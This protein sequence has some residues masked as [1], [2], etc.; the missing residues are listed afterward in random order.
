MKKTT[1]SCLSLIIALSM[2]STFG[3]ANNENGNANGEG[4]AVVKVAN[5]SDKI[6]Q[7]YMEESRIQE[8]FMGNLTDSFSFSAYQNEYESKQLIITALEDVEIFDVEIKDFKNGEN[9]LDASSFEIYQEF[10]HEVNYMTSAETSMEIGYYPDALIPFETAKAYGI[11]KIEKGNNQGI[12][13]TLFV[14]KGQ[15]PG[16]YTG[17]I[18]V[19]LNN[20]ETIIV[21]GA[22]T[23]F[24]Y[25]LPD[26]VSL[27]TCVPLQAAYITNGELNATEDLYYKYVDRLNKYR[28]SVMFLDPNGLKSG[29]TNE[30]YY[31]RAIKEAELAVDATNDPAVSAYA[32][33]YLGVASAEW[34][35]KAILNENVFD[36]YLRAYIDKS[37]ETGVD[38]FKKAYL[39]LGSIIDEPFLTN[40]E[41]R[42]NYVCRQVED[43][44]LIA[45]EYAKE[46]NASEELLESIKNFKHI[47]TNAWQ[48]NLQDVTYYVPQTDDL[49]SATKL[50]LYQ[51][52]E[53]EGKGF[54]WYNCGIPVAPYVNI[55]IDENGPAT[56][57]MGW[58]AKKFNIGGWLT[59][60]SAYYMNYNGSS[61]S[62]IY[63]YDNY[64]ISERW[65][66]SFGD[67]YVFYPG[68]VFG[69]D[70]PV[71]SIRLPIM[72]DGLEEYEALNDLENKYKEF[73]T[74]FGENISC[75][76]LLNEIYT[77]LFN[78][79]KVYASSS[80]LDEMHVVLGRLLELANDGIAISDFEVNYDGTLS[81][82]VYSTENVNV[83]I[84]GNKVDFAAIANGY[85]A[86]VKTTDFSFNVQTSSLSFDMPIGNLVYISDLKNVVS[87]IEFRN[88]S[89]FLISTA[90]ADIE[91][92]PGTNVDA[93][94][95]AFN[96]DCSLISIPLKKNDLNKDV[97]KITLEMYSDV[98]MTVTLMAQA[99]NK[100]KSLDSFVVQ[101]GFNTIEIARIQNLGLDSLLSSVDKIYFSFSVTTDDN[102]VYLLGMKAVK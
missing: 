22:I 89:Q 78:R 65:P 20:S 64:L 55:H 52:L 96:K 40:S 27:Q 67:G 3:C 93:L 38:I 1:K 35:N 9:K 29:S 8:D 7:S 51:N 97:R 39:Y 62:P 12:Y 6:L 74:I 58:M 48:S 80:E 25:E 90:T 42:A 59:W 26:T 28:L 17:S 34:N 23:I 102:N 16:V 84:N 71:D 60:E 10:Y 56:R 86:T 100:V 36:I 21:N 85:S 44:I 82:K 37:I 63:G 87:N 30:E 53:K 24:D 68:A 69:I 66:G 5:S 101:E 54:W 43:R 41:E 83:K 47:V 11:N 75:D 72:R 81:C 76:G 94:H 50:D 32:M 98:K 14:P 91:K 99:G 2:C 4:Q 79:V 77:Y 13:I 61:A 31:A 33:N 73:S 19:S 18:E 15:E 92:V 95:L 49:E 57:L 46:Q 45:L 70:G 88:L